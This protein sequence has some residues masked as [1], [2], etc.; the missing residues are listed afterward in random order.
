MDI[1][2]RPPE[3]LPEYL[4]QTPRG[5]QPLLSS[6]GV[7]FHHFLPPVRD[8]ILAASGLG[9]GRYKATYKDW[10]GTYE[11]IWP[12]QEEFLNVLPLNIREMLLGSAPV[13]PAGI[14]AVLDSYAENGYPTLE[15]KEDQPRLSR[16]LHSARYAEIERAQA[17]E[18]YDRIQAR[19]TELGIPWETPDACDDTH[20]DQWVKI[21][22]GRL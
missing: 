15:R 14:T 22:Q 21:L 10:Y 17:R 13:D 9:L 12:P 6:R 2:L 20:R 18:R 8:A 1:S 11:A 16:L 3:L 19:A 7:M 4:H 5:I